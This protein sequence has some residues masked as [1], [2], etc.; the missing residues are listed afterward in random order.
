MCLGKKETSEIFGRVGHSQ[1][2]PLIPDSHW[3]KRTNLIV[4]RRSSCRHATLLNETPNTENDRVRD[5]SWRNAR[6]FDE[7]FAQFY[8]NPWQSWIVD[9]MLWIP[10]SRFW[11][12]D[13]WS[14]KFGFRILIV[15]EWDSGFF[16]LYSAFRI[17][18]FLIF[19]KQKFSGFPYM[20]WNVWLWI[21][22]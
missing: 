5:Y 6:L 18:G 8:L 2:S 22:L 10:D 11:I 4:R 12:L 14:V 21:T 7:R 1:N 17:P 20:G 3:V 16:E 15:T 13:S 9:C 19:H